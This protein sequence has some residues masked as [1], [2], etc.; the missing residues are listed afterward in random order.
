MRSMTWIEERDSFSSS[1]AAGGLNIR[2]KR[3]EFYIMKFGVTSEDRS[4]QCLRV[5]GCL[6]LRIQPVDATH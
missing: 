5:N 6:R 1:T 2:V 4:R 3:R